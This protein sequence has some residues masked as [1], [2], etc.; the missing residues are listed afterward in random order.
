MSVSDELIDRAYH[1]GVVLPRLDW[2]T[3]V[4]SGSTAQMKYKIRVLCDLH[5]YNTTCTKFCRPRND[6]FGH[7]RCDASGDKIC[8]DGW[9]GR[10]CETG[11][12]FTILTKLVVII[13]SEFTGSSMC[14]CLACDFPYMPGINNIKW[15]EIVRKRE[16]NND[17]FN[18][19]IF[20]RT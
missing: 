15:L 16:Y 3:I 18:I 1:S 9:I 19:H 8:Y 5:Y 13:S 11:N 12:W 20:G 4:H 2:Q 17:R 10:N 14:F 6:K 7:Y